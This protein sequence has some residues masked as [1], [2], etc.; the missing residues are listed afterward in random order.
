MYPHQSPR[1]LNSHKI[2]RSMLQGF[3][4]VELLVV[5]S[6]I[7]L[8]IAVL[9]PALSKARLAAQS[10][11]CLSNLR[12]QGVAAGVYFAENKDRFPV[13]YSALSGGTYGN[14]LDFAIQSLAYIMNGT[15]LIDNNAITATKGLLCPSA[16]RPNWTYGNY[17]FN[18]A[19]AGWASAFE[20]GTGLPRHNL[21]APGDGLRRGAR[22]G[23]VVEPSRKVYGMDF[24]YRSMN[25]NWAS[26]NH[27]STGTPQHYVPGAGSHGVTT[28]LNTTTSNWLYPDFLTGRH[29][30]NVNM[31]YVDS[32]AA[33]V[34]GQLAVEKYHKSS[35][36][37]YQ[38]DDNM[39]NIYKK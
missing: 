26:T 19:N 6:I 5:I 11:A 29:L 28:V 16:V 30:G 4:L 13:Q 10:V 1:Q 39:F 20:P 18:N 31:L 25:S 32:H 7:A 21:G 37:R 27:T 38:A 14:S 24:G 15:S 23:D 12:Q 36:Q 17:G 34:S 9:L 8:L 2:N 3:T 33:T 35:G 22:F